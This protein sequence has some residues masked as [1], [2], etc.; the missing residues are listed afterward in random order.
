MSIYKFVNHA[1]DI[2]NI[3][4]S[5]AYRIYEQLQKVGAYKKLD[6]E[7]KELC[8]S[9]FDELFHSETYK[10]GIYKIGGYI[11]DFTQ[12]QKTYL[13]KFKYFGWLEIKAFNKSIIRDCSTNPS[14][15]IKIVELD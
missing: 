11:I 8:K 1:K 9:I 3:K 2:E 7:Y 4:S 5:H 6:K 13:V 14:Y 12:Y 10:N 15:I